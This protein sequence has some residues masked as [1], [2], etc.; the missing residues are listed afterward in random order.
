MHENGS[1]RPV[2]YHNLTEHEREVTASVVALHPFAEGCP[3]RP[4]CS[5]SDVRERYGLKDVVEYNK[6]GTMRWY[7]HLER[8]NGTKTKRICRV[9]VCGGKVGM[10]TL[11]N[12]MYLWRVEKEPNFKH[13]KPTSLRE[14]ID[15]TSEVREIC[16]DRIVWKSIVSVYSSEK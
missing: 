2:R 5:S 14:K 9:N 15:D 4:V 11:E 1:A 12:S 10:V 3:L 13:S 6:K 8:I 16:K 7:G